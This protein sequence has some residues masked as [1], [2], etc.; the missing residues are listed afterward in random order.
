MC[1]IATILGPFLH[2][3]QYLQI[4]SHFWIIYTTL[5]ATKIYPSHS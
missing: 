5:I 2:N 3:I 1:K 4:K